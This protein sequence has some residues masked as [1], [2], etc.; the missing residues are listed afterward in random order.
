MDC[1][2]IIFSLVQLASRSKNLTSK[3]NTMEQSSKYFELSYRRI[4][5]SYSPFLTQ[6]ICYITPKILVAKKVPN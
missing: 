5:M 2:S 1:Y 6:K 3:K 4:C